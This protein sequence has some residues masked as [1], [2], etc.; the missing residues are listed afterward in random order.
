M[1]QKKEPEGKSDQEFLVDISAPADPKGGTSFLKKN[2]K[3]L[4]IAAVIVLVLLAA[5]IIVPRMLARK[6]ASN[7]TSTYV[8][9][10]PETRDI[11]NEFSDDGTINAA[12]SYSVTSLVSGDV[13]TA[14]FEV[15]DVVQKG[16]VL[17]TI[18]SSDAQTKLE[19]AQLTLEQAQQN[20]DDAVDA[21]YI[22]STVAG[23]VDTLNVRVGDVISAGQ[24]I[25]VVRDNSTLLLKLDFPA[26]SAAGFYVGQAV[27][28]TVNGTFEQIP[29]AIQ[30]ISGTDQLSSGNLLTRTVTIVVNNAGGNLTTAQAA[31]ASID[32]VS[33]IGSAHFEY[34]RE[35]S[36]TSSSA[37]TVEQIYASEGSAVSRDGA[38]V[39]I[40]DDSITKQINSYNI[41]LRNAEI[42]LQNAQDSVD[43][44]TITAPISGTIV[45]KDVK[46]GE[47]ISAGS[48]SATTLCVIYDLDY[49]EMELSVDEL[50]V[51]DLSEGMTATVTADAV[52]DKTYQGV[53]TSVLMAGS[54]SAGTT[55]YP[56]T[57]R[58]DNTDGL[59]PGMNGT[60]V[61]D[62]ESALGALSVPNAAIVRGNYVL[63]TQDSP[64]AANAV[65][66]MTAPDGY[67][68]VQVTTGVSDNDYIEIK[69]GLTAEDT[70]AYDSDAAAALENSAEQ[71][72][73]M[74]GFG[75]GMG[76][77]GMG[78]GPGG[79]GPGGGMR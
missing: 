63:V 5:L 28:V 12:D 75:G 66:D 49:F 23:V 13:L 11:T 29:G 3:R 36:I 18:D 20:Y 48:S 7:Q 14:D 19:Q 79:G 71:G 32:G 30:S 50:E 57:I 39:R 51:G 76:G 33:S 62:V 9:T 61:I 41:S 17:Y 42:S 21:E 40:S 67:V 77:G 1:L 43:D 22:R 6:A 68:Y 10:K 26:A 54:T 56:V 8:E 24:E 65:S 16:D 55:V 25:A 58:I 44:Y 69:S 46:A 45:E 78:G 70:I 2:R 15:G 72:M 53:I 60:A 27:T 37:G 52:S 47:K 38:I 34:Q 74:G 59:M 31:D 64:S 35:Q 73:M 4:I